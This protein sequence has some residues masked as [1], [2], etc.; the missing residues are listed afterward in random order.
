MKT[1]YLTPADDVQSAVNALKGP[2][3]VRLSNGIYRQKIK[4]TADDITI[5]G[6][7][8]EKTVITFDDYAKKPHADG[9]EYNT[10]RTYT[11]CVTGKRVK[12]ENLTVENSNTQPEVKGQCVA[13]SVNADGFIAENV[14]LK[15][16]QDTLFTAPFP[17]DLV[18]RYSGLTED[19]T[20][21]AGFISK[22]ELCLEGNLVQL[23]KNCR[24]YGTV[25]YVFGC[26][27]AY[28]IG[29][30]FISL[31]EARGT[32]FVAAPA[33]SLARSRGYVF[34]ECAF[35]S[36]GAAKNSVY[37]A[38]PW[39]DFGKCEFINCRLESHING[40]L[41]DKWNDTHRNK[42]ARFYYFSL[43]SEAPLTPVK[44]ASELTEKQANEIINY[45]N[46]KFKGNAR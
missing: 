13:L 31:P 43:R 33:H 7:N 44:W 41:F 9:R 4:I 28:F 18:I 22:D 2:A 27:E 3:T 46:A 16:T 12:I 17:D 39:R 10:F 1:M 19:K 36:G 5:I 20:Y 37:L 25:D 29:C 40:E 8:R 23:F 42:T 34:Y 32:G 14:D 26:A 30:Q 38:R 15:S 35:K 21:Y 6:E 45:C 24:I 11:L